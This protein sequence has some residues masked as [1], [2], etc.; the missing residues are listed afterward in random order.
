MK[1]KTKTHNK[2]R[3]TALVYEMLVKY[4]TK[5]MV[6]NN[7]REIT[8]VK[9]IL[10]EFFTKDKVLSKELELYR[11]L[12]EPEN[13]TRD[14]GE[15]II[16]EVVNRYSTMDKKLLFH[17]QSNL[18]NTINKK[19]GKNV[20]EMFVP[21]Y[22]TLASIYQLF[23]CE[24]PPKKKVMLEQNLCEGLMSPGENQQKKIVT[25]LKQLEYKIY[26]EKFNKEYASLLTE[27]KVLLSN[28]MLDG[29]KNTL[30]FKL[31]LNEEIGRIK[32]EVAGATENEFIK[33]DR[34]LEDKIEELRI[35]L[36]DFSKKEFNESMLKKL[37]KIQQF[38]GEIKENDNQIK[39]NETTRS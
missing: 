3:N 24:L 19:I 35:L 37:L 4:L 14:T 5:C 34:V 23:N 33:E 32:L 21:N 15:R 9:T 20:Y 11:S 2:K 8:T 38:L 17:E 27:Q 12:S 25:P 28:Y 39:T 16:K 13:F 29:N 7:K 6:E 22:R 31:Y 10:K 30:E 36:E 26:I 18:I 1:R